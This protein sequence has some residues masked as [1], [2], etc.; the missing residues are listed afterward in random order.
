LLVDRR[1][2]RRARALVEHADAI[3]RRERVRG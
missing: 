3:A 2:M 1:T